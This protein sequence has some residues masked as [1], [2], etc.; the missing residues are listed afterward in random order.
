MDREGIHDFYQQLEVKRSQIEDHREWV[1]AP[2]VLA[3]WTHDSRSDSRASAGISVHDGDTSIYHCF[4]CHERGPL[5]RLLERLE[6]LSGDDYAELKDQFE[7]SEEFGPPL[8]AWEKRDRPGQRETLGEPLSEDYMRLYEWPG[9]YPEARSYLRSRGI[10]AETCK[11]LQIQ[12]DPDDR[13]ILFPVRDVS[14]RLY[15]FSG[16]AIDH[17]VNPRIKDYFGLPKRLLLLGAERLQSAVMVLIVEG[18][19]DY[20]ALAQ[21]GFPTVAL[22]GTE[23]TDGKAEVLK[24]LNL[25][26]YCFTDFDSPGFD[27]AHGIAQAL[28]RHVPV[29]E[30]EYPDHC[31]HGDDPA[32]LSRREIEMMIEDAEFFSV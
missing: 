9:R 5:V 2:C 28:I 11:R 12:Y 19:F 16:R 24:Q 23:L 29:F 14:G 30:V 6:Q 22:L 20:A 17:G 32:K 21:Y 18:L 4:T 13:R 8:P 3:P 31:A 10:T 7:V 26:V 1:M 27:A 15:G 25:P